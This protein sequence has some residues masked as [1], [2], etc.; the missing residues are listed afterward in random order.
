MSEKTLR[1]LSC[2]P[3]QRYSF[4]EKL[5]WV[6][7]MANKHHPDIFVLP[8][9]YHSGLQAVMFAGKTDEQL[10]YTENQIIIPYLKLAER[11]NM[12]ITVGAIVK[13]EAIGENRERVWV[14][15]PE[16]GVTGRADK[17]MLPAYDH[18]DAGGAAQVFPEQVLENR[19]QAFECKGARISVL[20]C[21]EAFSSFIWHAISR[22]QPDFVVS[23]IKFGV[24][25][26][27][28][29][30]KINGKSLVKGFG[31]GADGGWIE[32]LQMAAR[33]DIAAPIVCSTNSWDLPNKAGALAGVILPWEEKETSG[34]YARPARTS[35]L[36]N[37]KEQGKGNIAEHVQV[38]E[39][40]FLYW[41]FIRAHKFTL[42]EETGEW[43]SSEARSF[44]MSWKVRRMERGLTGLPALNAPSGAKP[45][46]KKQVSKQNKQGALFA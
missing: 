39:V 37:S 4:I 1:V 43:P 41:R 18:V 32:R 38:N 17:I 34:E 29:K 33:W 8:Q 25:G 42:N 22:A 28:Q 26:W 46:A 12:G 14:I 10:V 19:A 23:M 9:E 11:Y 31:F 16:K 36:W 6:N 21:W 2:V 15:D 44:T 13:D 7:A 30:E 5:Q 24:C 27:P 45:F 35:S 40:D 3:Q 20:F